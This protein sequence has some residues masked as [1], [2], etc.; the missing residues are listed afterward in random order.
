[1]VEIAVQNTVKELSV[2]RLCRLNNF[3]NNSNFNA[4]DWNVDNPNNWFRGIVQDAE[5]SQ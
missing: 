3:D 1:M 5:I 4:N 2:A